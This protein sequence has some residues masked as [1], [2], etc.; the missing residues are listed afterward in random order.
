VEVVVVCELVVVG[1]VSV[2]VLGLVVVPPLPE[3]PESS[4]ATMIR[5]TPSPITKAMRIPMVQRVRLSTVATVVG[6]SE[7]SAA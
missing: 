4:A 2:G 6:G 7:G 5:A 1:S 3:S